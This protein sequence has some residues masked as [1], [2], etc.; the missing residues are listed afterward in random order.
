MPRAQ[1]LQDTEPRIAAL[2]QL[3]FEELSH[4]VTKARHMV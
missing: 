4:R 3:F 1:Y 2:A